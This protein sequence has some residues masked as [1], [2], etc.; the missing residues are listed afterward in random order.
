MSGRL[1]CDCGAEL[2]GDGFGPVAYRDEV[3]VLTCPECWSW[4]HASANLRRLD[5]ARMMREP[6][7]VPWIIK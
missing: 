5:V 3:G 4:L 6:P 7:P 1:R 2:L